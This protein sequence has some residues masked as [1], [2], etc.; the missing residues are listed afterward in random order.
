MI[1]PLFAHLTGRAL[2]AL[3]GP[4]W[5]A[6][7][8][9]LLSNEVETLAPGQARAALLLTPQGKYLFDLFVV[10]GQDDRG[11]DFAMLDVQA[12]RR[13]ALIARLA[14]YRLR[15]KV[16]IEAMEGTVFVSWGGEAAP[17]RDGAW[18][19]PRHFRSCTSL[20]RGSAMRCWRPD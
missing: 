19:R 8:Q 3:R 20:P 10:V 5:R 15:A 7:L 9:N 18:R 1:M 13:E 14:P 17:G 2:V 16:Q 6:F 4:D 11:E 12:D